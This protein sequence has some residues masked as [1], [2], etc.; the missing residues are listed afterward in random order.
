[1]S[2]PASQVIVPE[3]TGSTSFEVFFRAN[4][5]RLAQAC[6]LLTGDRQEAQD[7]AQE[8][9][10]RL[11]A[12]WDRIRTMRSPEGYLYRTALNVI[13]KKKARPRRDEQLLDQIG[14]A[15][16]AV[17]IAERDRIM[18]ALASLPKRQRETLVLA[19]WLDLD[20]AEVGRTL[21]I[22]ESSVR[23]NLHRARTT[24][25]AELGEIDD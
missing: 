9:L 3:E 10:A 11:Y 14:V 13:R 21:G 2:R 24:L 1:M 15:D 18:R 7:T 8:S 4:Y 16:P 5:V 19:E 25:R 23:V 22:A 12:R 20:T 6:L 17:D